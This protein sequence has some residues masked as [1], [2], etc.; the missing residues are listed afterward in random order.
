[1]GGPNRI[2]YQ[3]YNT[4]APT[5]SVTA[6]AS[7]EEGSTDTINVSAN[8]VTDGTTL[9]WTVTPA[10]DFSI[11]YGSFNI[12]NNI[13][14]FTLSAVQD[15]VTEGNE[16]ATI[17]IRTGSTSGTVVATTTFTITEPVQL[18][19]PT[20][21]IDVP[22]TITVGTSTTVTVITQNVS[23]GTVLYWEASPTSSFQVTS[24]SS[25]QLTINSNRGSFTLT[26]V[27]STSTQ[28]ILTIRTG[29]PT[30]TSVA[31]STFTIAPAPTAPPPS[32]G[33][34]STASLAYTRR[35]STRRTSIINALVDKIKDI[36]GRGDFLTELFNNVH[37]RLK[38]WD[39]VTEFPAV[40]LSAGSETREYQG[41]G[42][43]DRFLSVTIRCYVNEEDAIEA[44]DKLLEDIETVLETNSQLTYIDKQGNSQK[45][46][47]IS[48]ISIDTDEGV[49]EPLGVGEILIEVRY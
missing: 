30:G 47:Q 1:M 22:S 35:Y 14:S 34:T 21:F 10:A 8:N 13:G 6:P 29:S 41:G 37:P 39:E 33:G 17:E 46:H 15:S 23:N 42:Y 26:A 27:S 24:V 31:T 48:I 12:N 25:G 19:P 11:S 7:I 36:D 45:T 2:A 4:L 20:Y 5:Y 28:G 44:L 9:Y 49:L 18:L 3:Q 40:H 16:T 38:F 32:S 43:R